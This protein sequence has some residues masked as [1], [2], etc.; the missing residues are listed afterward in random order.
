MLTKNKIFTPK[1]IVVVSLL[2]L[3]SVNISNLIKF[4]NYTRYETA[5]LG[6]QSIWSYYLKFFWSSTLYFGIGIITLIVLLLKSQRKISFLLIGIY[7]S[8][9]IFVKFFLLKMDVI[10][11]LKFL[12]FIAI[13]I[14][15]FNSEFLVKCQF[16]LKNRLFTL[17]GMTIINLVFF[18]TV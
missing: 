10:T 7:L 13:L 11:C 5:Y 3:L 9:E 4:I 2:F 15:Y 12:V 6:I 1:L 17:I 8:H 18:Y 16:S 14:E